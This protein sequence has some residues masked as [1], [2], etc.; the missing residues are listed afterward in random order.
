M[1]LK[2]VLMLS[3]A[4]LAAGG[5]LSAQNLIVGAD[6]A[7]RF[8]NR[9]YANN[10][11]NESQTL[12]SARF[13]PRIG[14]EWME[15]NRLIFGVDLLQ[16]FGQHNGAR[17]PFL[18]DVKPLIYYQFNSKNVQ[19]NAG[20][21]DRKELLGDY[22]RAFFSDSTAFYHN[23]LSGF[24]G[25][26]KSTERENTYVEMA[27]DWEGMYSEQSREMFRIISA[28][29]YTLERGFYFGYAFSMFHFAGSKLNEN[30]TDNLL[31]NPYAGWGF[32]AFFDFDIKAGFLFAPQRGR[33]VDHNWKK[34][35]G[36]QIDFVLTK[37]GV[38]L[39]NNLYLGENLQP[40]AQHRG[41]E[42]IPITYGQDGLYAGE[43]FYATTE[44]IYNRTW[45]GY[46]RRFFKGTLAVEAGMVFH[47][48]GT[49]MGTQQVVKLSVDIQKLFNI[50]PKDPGTE[51]KHTTS[52]I[53]TYGKR[54]KRNTG[55]V[56]ELPR[57]DHRR[58][59]RQGRNARPDP[60]SR[61]NPNGYLHIGHAKSI[62]INFGLAKKYGGKCNLRFDDTN[63]VKEDVEYV[64][65]IKRDIQWLGFDWAVE[66]YASDYFDQL[67]DWAIVL[68]KKGLAYVDDQT[69][70]QI[71]ENR[72]TVSVPGTPSPWRDRSVEEN[73]DLFVRMKNGEFPRR[74]QGAARQDRHGAP[75][76]ALPRPD[77][78]PHHP[79][80][81]SPHGQQVVHLP[82]VRLCPRPER[83]DRADHP[84]DLHA[85]IRRAPSS[86]TGS[87]RR[88]RSTL[89]TST[90]SPG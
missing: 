55:E 24:L 47:Y 89:R 40:L 32:N 50:G 12:F 57:R 41:G 64:D 88:W 36:A 14:V 20:I 73:L 23:R 25:H 3:F 49:G 61:P 59:D 79:C 43:P 75:Q 52:E 42:D 27:I 90:N 21:F 26:Y 18:S 10:D 74:G 29:R 5:S 1:S 7:T 53:Y 15:K 84:L 72:G 45:V 71:R 16:N 9:E 31:V 35:C 51:R 44:H 60:V 76:H 30:V 63:P 2:K 81:A 62:C 56:A 19:A 68:I 87:S 66:R 77:H 13:T 46:D 37:W 22:S 34:P 38:K 65:S 48:D 8:D 28:G 85:R 83:L 78:V 80:R 17:E 70:E 54:N 86:T 82:D 33:S 4:A 6:F 69:Q 39:E 11:F 58:V 67:Y